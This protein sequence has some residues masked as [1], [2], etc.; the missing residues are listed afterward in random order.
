MAT[1][2]LGSGRY[3]P[4]FWY[5]I[6]R[7]EG[8]WTTVGGD[9]IREEDIDIFSTDT[10][11]EDCAMW[12]TSPGMQNDLFTSFFPCETVWTAYPLCEYNCGITCVAPTAPDDGSTDCGNLT[13]LGGTCTALCDSGYEL[14]G[15][16]TLTC[17]DVDGD[18]IGEFSA[19]PTC[20]GI[21]LLL[22]LSS[23]SL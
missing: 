7:D 4:W 12:L 6:R 13:P 17:Q 21:I 14:T 1:G 10:S 8:Q 9:V 22:V 18:G 11:D 3:V 5:G 19:L 23:V 15:T 16:A 20:T 2:L